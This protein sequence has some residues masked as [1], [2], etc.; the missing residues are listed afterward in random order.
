MIC[1]YVPES[2]SCLFFLSIASW[3][4]EVSNVYEVWVN[5]VF[6]YSYC[7]FRSSLE[8]P[9]YPQVTKIFSQF[10]LGALSFI[11]HTKLVFFVHVQGKGSDSFFHVN[12]QY[13]QF[14][15]QKIL[16]FSLSHIDLM[17]FVKIKFL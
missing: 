16:S 10:L 14:Y 9:C 7:I 5:N 11:I 8:I 6:Y 13:F 2:A 12:I 3:G 15:W 17:S 1:K 4:T